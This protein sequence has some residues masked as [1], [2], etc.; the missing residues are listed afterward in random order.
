[1]FCGSRSRLAKPDRDHRTDITDPAQYR[2]TRTVAISFGTARP[3]EDVG[4]FQTRIGDKGMWGQSGV[5]KSKVELVL[6]ME[7]AEELVRIVPV[8]GR[9]GLGGLLQDKVVP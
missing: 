4:D 5:G 1:M 9:S 6:T 3:G 8:V 7:S 2:K